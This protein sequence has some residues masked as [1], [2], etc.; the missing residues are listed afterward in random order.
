[1]IDLLSKATGLNAVPGYGKST[2]IAQNIT[3]NDL[4][5]TMTSFAMKALSAKMRNTRIKVMTLENAITVHSGEIQ[6]LYIDEAS[7]MTPL[8]I[9]PLIKHKVN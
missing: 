1:M 6:T 2:E 5:V 3:V 8:D 9:C 4:A 7:M